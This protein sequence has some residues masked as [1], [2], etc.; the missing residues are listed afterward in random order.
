ILTSQG[1]NALGGVRNY[2][3]NGKMTEGYGLVAYPAEYGVTGVMTF[4]VNQDGI[5]YQKN[6][7]KSTA[8]AVNAIKAFDP[9]KTWKQVQ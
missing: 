3:V 1:K 7:G 4:I 5:I 9:D 6:L 2:V 8:Q